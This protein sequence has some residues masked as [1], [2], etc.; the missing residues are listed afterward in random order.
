M[1]N[2]SQQSKNQLKKDLI[3]IFVFFGSVIVLMT[4]IYFLDQKMGFINQFSEKLTKFLI[5]Q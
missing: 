1:E 5:S 4:V 3:K 2:E